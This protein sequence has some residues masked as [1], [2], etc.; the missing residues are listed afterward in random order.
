MGAGR[1]RP[2]VVE[3]SQQAVLQVR[4]IGDLDGLI[5]EILVDQRN[6]DALR[7]PI[8]PTA[9]KR[10]TAPDMGD[11]AGAENIVDQLFVFILLVGKCAA[12]IGE[13]GEGEGHSQAIQ[14]LFDGFKILFN[15]A[16]AGI[17]G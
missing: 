17:V 15:K 3:E 5:V 11:L 7:A 9:I 10:M 4:L 8:E 13:V 12:E 6:I 1:Q 2:G 16:C 14:T